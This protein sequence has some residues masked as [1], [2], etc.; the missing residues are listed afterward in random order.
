M[1]VS[2]Y[3]ATMWVQSFH[4]VLYSTTYGQVSTF[5]Q[6]PVCIWFFS[7]IPGTLDQ[8]SPITL[9]TPAGGRLCPGVVFTNTQA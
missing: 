8:I 5:C 2:T 6:R 4:L 7:P 9:G 3:Q 1:A